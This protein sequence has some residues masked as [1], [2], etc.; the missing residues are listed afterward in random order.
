LK[1]TP[2]AVKEGALRWA[3]TLFVVILLIKLL[4][5]ELGPWLHWDRGWSCVRVDLQAR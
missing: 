1:L 4:L 3:S 5:M 2:E